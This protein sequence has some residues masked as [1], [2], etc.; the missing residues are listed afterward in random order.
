MAKNVIVS[1]KLEPNFDKVFAKNVTQEI[2]SVLFK[3][4]S[5]LAKGIERRIQD[6]VKRRIE[7]SSEYLAIVG[8]N[9]RGQLGLPDGARRIQ[10]IISIWIESITAKG[11][12]SKG[13][14]LGSIDIGIF[15][16]GW[17]DVMA[18]P[19][20]ILNYTNNQGQ[21]K[22]LEWLRW[23]LLEGD[24]TIVAGFDFVSSKRGRT[25]LGVMVESRG[26]SWK[27]PAQFTGTDRDNFAI[28]ALVGANKEIEKMAEQEFKRIF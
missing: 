12:I 10:E 18:S 24:K 27:V 20:A 3:S 13:R 14:L 17:S 26:G 8:G 4:L 1:L 21:T 23:L 6:I 28:R 19:A 5:S 25:G 2:R 16:E 15:R 7:Q 9:L 11:R 22:S